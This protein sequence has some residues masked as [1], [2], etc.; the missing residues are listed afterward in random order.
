MREKLR[1]WGDGITAGH[2]WHRL[3]EKLSP[4]DSHFL[5]NLF[6]KSG[7]GM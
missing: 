4:L 6:K 3:C 7:V 1:H 5:N 2:F